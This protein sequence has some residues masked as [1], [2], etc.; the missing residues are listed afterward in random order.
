MKQE[1]HLKRYADIDAL[2]VIA[3]LCITAIHYIGYSGL[4]DADNIL[5]INK[6]LFSIIYNVSI[7]SINLFAIISGYLLSTKPFS[8]RRIIRLWFDVFCTSIV[9]FII[10]SVAFGLNGWWPFLSSIL[11]VSTFG[12]WY[13]NTH[14]MLLCISPLWNMLIAKINARMHLLI[15]HILTFVFSVFLMMNPFVDAKIYIGHGHG[16][17]WFSMLYLWGAYF[18]RKER[19]LSKRIGVMMLTIAL[20]SIT[21]LRLFKGVVPF[22]ERFSMFEMNSPFMIMIA[23]SLFMLIKG[24]QIESNWINAGLR[25]LAECSLFVYLIQEHNAVRDGLWS[26][27]RITNIADRYTIWIEFALA[28][29]CIWPIAYAMKRI[30]SRLWP[31]FEKKIMPI[32]GRIMC[33]SY[34]RRVREWLLS[35]TTAS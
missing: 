20:I 29:S 25:S 28:L 21:V 22:I 24:I 14:M 31:A 26:L 34:V 9:W 15:C 12:Y 19:V 32:S 23:L 30:T 6:V 16:I 1:K 4:L 3:M 18:A 2:K 11:P 8:Y 13:I 10:G 5:P 33:C 35:K 7:A 17:V 27:F